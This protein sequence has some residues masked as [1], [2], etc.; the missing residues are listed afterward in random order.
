LFLVKSERVQWAQKATT[1]WFIFSDFP[2][3]VRAV[4]HP[5]CAG[6][7]RCMRSCSWGRS[8]QSSQELVLR[9]QCSAV[10]TSSTSHCVVLTVRLFVTSVDL[11]SSVDSRHP[12]QFKKKNF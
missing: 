9:K 2:G 10:S 7:R 4:T 3:S 11:Q 6:M 5:V 12:S 8:W 1:I